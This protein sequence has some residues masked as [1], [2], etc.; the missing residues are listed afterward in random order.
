MYLPR[1]SWLN[2]LFDETYTNA[3]ILDPWKIYKLLPDY[4]QSD[5]LLRLI[6]L[7]QK[8]SVSIRGL[9]K[10]L[11]VARSDL[12]EQFITEEEG[13]Q[14][15]ADVMRLIS[16]LLSALKNS[17]QEIMELEG[18]TEPEKLS[19]LKNILKGKITPQ[20][21]DGQEP[22]QTFSRLS[23]CIA[24][25]CSVKYIADSFQLDFWELW[26]ELEPL[27]PSSPETPENLP[28]LEPEEKLSTSEFLRCSDDDRAWWWKPDGDVHFSEGMNIWLGQLKAELDSLSPNENPD[29][30]A[31]PRFLVETLAG[32]AKAFPKVI[33][34]QKMFYDF[35]AH[36]DDPGTWVA[37]RLLENLK[38]RYLAEQDPD[39]AQ[40]LRRYLAVLGNLELRKEIFGF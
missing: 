32:V 3:R 18:R 11:A 12:I 14:S 31:F 29:P 36:A 30:K 16:R 9:F 21:L 37:V 22:Y 8:E 25:E 28:P 10:Y 35:L 38:D 1:K 17:I 2:G 39:G 33:P 24:P 23:A 40:K 6:P 26:L 5:D 4:R 13:E 34:F 20:D 19:V 15:A 7:S 27:I